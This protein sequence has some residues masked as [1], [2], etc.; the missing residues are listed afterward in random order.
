MRLVYVCG[1]IE[2]GAD[3]DGA[4]I[5]DNGLLRSL[6]RLKIDVQEIG[7]DRSRSG[8]LPFWRSSLHQNNLLNQ[9][10]NAKQEDMKLV[11][12]HEAYF[13]LA[14]GAKVDVLIVHNYMPGFSFPGLRPLEHYYQLGSVRY[15][16]SA[17]KGARNIVFLSHRDL[18]NALGNHPHIEGRSCVIQPPPKSVDLGRRR[19]DL[20]HVSGS[21]AWLP[22]RLSRLSS[23]SR[24]QFTEKGFELADFGS[25]PTPA[26]GLI[27][28]RFVVGFKLKLMQMM[29]SRDVIASTV[30]LSDEIE[31]IVGKYPFWRHV[32]RITD[33]IDWFESVKKRMSADEIDEVFDEYPIERILPHWD[34]AG[35]VIAR[36]LSV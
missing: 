26:F 16:E 18:K 3:R 8:K 25:E 20:V 29:Y 15:F 23:R 9:I 36:L 33:A 1:R 4:Q 14:F 10:A 27:H 34:D 7:L 2:S 5:F 32:S 24:Q 19:V 12:S 30:D 13:E 17:F 21:G 22:K 28:D 35:A 31:A 11:V 6:D